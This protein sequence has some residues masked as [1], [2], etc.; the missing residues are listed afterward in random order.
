ML[1][2][3]DDPLD[4]LDYHKQIAESGFPIKVFPSFR[5][6]RFFNIGNKA[7][8]LENIQKLGAITNTDITSFEA[9]LSALEARV[10]YFHSLGCRVSDHGL[11]SMPASYTFGSALEIE[12]KQ[13]IAGETTSPFSQP[14]SFA[15]AVLFELCKMYHAR[16]WVQQ[17]HLGPIRNNNSRLLKQLGADAGVDSMGDYPQAVSLSNFLN[18]L[19]SS[20]QLAKTILYNLNPADNE[21][22]ATMCGNFSDGTTKGKMQYGSGWWFLDQKDG[23]EKQ[24]NALSNMGVVSNFIGMITDSRS[25]LSFSRHDYFRRVLCNLF[26]Q[27]M[28]NGLLPNDEVWIGEIIKDICYNN[29][30]NYFN[31]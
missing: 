18:G 31:F 29:A 17:F 4:N 16:G 3:T 24:L 28:E 23:I 1:G 7:G 10:D 5:P 19:D 27:E 2:T 11:T 8:F 6:D 14:D 12:F 20:D 22:M 9:L 15:G 21:L 13:F 26:G 30:K 25:F